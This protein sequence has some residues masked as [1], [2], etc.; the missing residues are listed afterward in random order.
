SG[1]IAAVSASETFPD[2][3]PGA[4]W[5]FVRAGTTWS[6]QQKIQPPDGTPLDS[7]GRALALY[8]DRIIVTATRFQGAQSFVLRDRAWSR[9]RSFLT[10]ALGSGLAFARQANV[11]VLARGDEAVDIYA[12]PL[13]VP[14]RGGGLP[15]ALLALLLAGLGAAGRRGVTG[16][17]GS[18]A[19]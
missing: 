19:C 15:A 18:R 9:E 16:R 4:V 8:G 6:V 1:D 13:R 5:M 10:K 14:A 17:P 3:P 2:S 12:S 11:A 7:F